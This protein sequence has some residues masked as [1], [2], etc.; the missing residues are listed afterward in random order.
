MEFDKAATLRIPGLLAVVV[1][2]DRLFQSMIMQGKKD[3]KR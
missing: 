2:V 1:S 3:S